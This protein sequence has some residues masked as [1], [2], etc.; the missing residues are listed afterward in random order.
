MNF[1]EIEIKGLIVIE[2]KVFEDERGY[3]YE[4]YNSEI[5]KEN[6]I[7]DVFVQDNESFSQKNVLRGLHFQ[8]P[9]YSQA[10]LIRVV[11]GSVLDVAGDLRKDS[12][13]Y[14]K[15]YTI[16]LSAENKKMFYIPTGF[17]HG[18]LTLEDDT[19]FSYKFSKI[20][21]KNA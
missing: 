6:G 7:E 8:N 10:K 3:F 15:H 17:A 13:T 18:F 11:Q 16:K 21:N 20:Y 1:V 14:G 12:K 5:F 4:S 9:P 19:I 2:P